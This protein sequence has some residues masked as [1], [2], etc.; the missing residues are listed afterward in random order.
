MSFRVPST[1]E[2]CVS[3]ILRAQQ[4]PFKGESPTSCLWLRRLTLERMTTSPSLMYL[5]PVSLIVTL[6]Q[7]FMTLKRWVSHCCSYLIIF[8]F[9]SSLVN[10]KSVH[11]YTFFYNKA[12]FVLLL[13]NYSSWFWTNVAVCSNGIWK[14]CSIDILWIIAFP[15]P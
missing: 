8:Y 9:F 11:K 5:C 15:I 4:I 6:Q 3:F 13:L 7:L 10:I 14:I 1:V 12:F 2:K